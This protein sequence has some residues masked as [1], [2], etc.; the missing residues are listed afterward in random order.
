MPILSS[1]EVRIHF[2]KR[3]FLKA[4]AL[5]GYRATIVADVLRY[6]IVSSVL[7]VGCGDGSLSRALIESG[8]TGTLVDVSEE[9]LSVADSLLPLS[10]RDRVRL[11]AQSIDDTGDLGL[12]S[13]VLCIGVLCYVNDLRRLLERLKQSL[14]E[15]GVLLLQFTDGST[16]DGCVV[17]AYLRLRRLVYPEELIGRLTWVSREQV[18]KECG[19][20]GLVVQHRR[21]HLIPFPG[22]RFLPASIQ[23]AVFSVS[24]FFGIGSEHYWVLSKAPDL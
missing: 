12:F 8:A 19:L 11:V 15:D 4:R 13:V 7:D 24:G 5:I 16:M 18:E 14:A 6:R 17:R 3:G 2:N 22:F 1:E 10:C 23:A 21:R 9:M 20:L